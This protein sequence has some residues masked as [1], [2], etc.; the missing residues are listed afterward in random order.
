MKTVYYF[1][2]EYYYKSGTMMGVLY[3]QE[4]NRYDWGFL[5]QDV[6]AGEEV[7]V[8]PATPEMIKW[9]NRVLKDV[10]RGQVTEEI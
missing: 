10:S 9:A 6:E 1:G 4:G 7:L 5:R 8:K 3:T 2:E